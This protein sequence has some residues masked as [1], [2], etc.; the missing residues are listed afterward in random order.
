M[1]RP[2]FLRS[3]AALLLAAAV[4][5]GAAGC[6]ATSED[7]ATGLDAAAFGE[8]VSTDGVVTIDVRTPAEYAE[9][10]LPDALNIDVE[11]GDF[12]QQIDG[13]DRDVPYA[14]YC[15]SGNR[16]AQALAQM[17]AAGFTD[18]AHLLGGIGAWQ[19]AGGTV[20]R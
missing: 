10:H 2:T 8:R 6:T 19:A 20:V 18:V 16:S 1:M 11:S 17:Q 4:A 3:L 15:R 5:V 9:G 13:L 12:A 14:L 7:T